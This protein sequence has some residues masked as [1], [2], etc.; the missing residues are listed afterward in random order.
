[1]TN[2]V[3]SHSIAAPPAL[4][5][6]ETIVCRMNQLAVR[7]GSYASALEWLYLNRYSQSQSTEQLYAMNWPIVGIAVQGGKRMRV[8]EQSFTYGGAR[9]FVAPVSLPITFQ[10]MQA[11]IT[12]PFLGIGLY[13]DPQRIAELVPN[14]YPQGLPPMDKR[15]AG[16]VIDADAALLNA[17]ARLLECLQDPGD[18]HLLA[19]LIRDEIYIRL[20]RSS[21]GVY[22]AETVFADSVVQRMVQAISWLRDHYDQPFKVPE[23]ASRIHLSESAFREQFKAVTG[24]SPLQYQKMLRLQESRRLMLSAG[25]DATSASRMVGYVSDSQFSRDYSRLFGDA[26]SRDIARLKMGSRPVV[27]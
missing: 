22:I 10:T 13:L 19:P 23:L 18:M 3:H 27:R 17:V 16:Y 26:P 15:E 8:G 7:E 14:V 25:M 12:E 24:F 4:T 6:M 9:L 20:L 1:M 11:S 5:E 21:V 2:S